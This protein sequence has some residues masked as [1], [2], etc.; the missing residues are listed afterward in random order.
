[1]GKKKNPDEPTRAEVKREITDI[2]NRLPEIEDLQDVLDMIVEYCKSDEALKFCVNDVERD[3]LKDIAA[4]KGIVV[5]N[6]DKM[7]LSVVKT[8]LKSMDVADLKGS[9]VAVAAQ[10]TEKASSSA[11]SSRRLRGPAVQAAVDNLKAI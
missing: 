1:M 2:L 3:Q 10:P 8:L 9:M 4:K 5:G 6:I 7:K 11:G